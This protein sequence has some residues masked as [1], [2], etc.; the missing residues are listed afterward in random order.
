MLR[1]LQQA[2]AH[3]VLEDD[4]RAAV[5][6]IAADAGLSPAAR[7][8]IHRTNTIVS[9]LAVLQAAYPAICRLVGE[10]KFNFVARAYVR[11][12]PPKVPQLSSYGWRFANFLAT[13]PQSRNIPYMPDLARLEWAR[14][15]ALF[16]SDVDPIDVAALQTVPA[17]RYGA[18][19]FALHPSVSA[20]ASRYAIH[21]V[22]DAYRADRAEPLAVDP[23]AAAE[24]VL[25]LRP[26]FA[27]ESV[28][29]SPGDFT[30]LLALKAGASL[31]AAASAAVATE[32]SLDLQTA[33]LGH[34]TR[35]TF[36]GFS[37]AQ[38]E[39]TQP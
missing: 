15:K 2:F 28:V 5:A 13:F 10:D 37:I 35:G 12:H 33:L 11:A 31:E 16:A 14:N 39:E 29:I 18:L 9:L 7:F 25:V 23:E 1:E 4:D 36:A 34:L 30:L 24:H 22:W 32:P 6:A 20:I 21:R 3:G 8:G 17:D 27:V 19:A 26:R 38:P